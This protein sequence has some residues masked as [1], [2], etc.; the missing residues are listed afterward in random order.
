MTKKVIIFSSIDFRR[1]PQLVIKRYVEDG[2]FMEI[3]L[4]GRDWFFCAVD[5]VL[6][7]FARIHPLLMRKV[8]Y[9]DLTRM[10]GWQTSAEDWAPWPRYRTWQQSHSKS[11]RSYE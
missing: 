5:K 9:L 7:T 2:P 10:S 8:T 6:A 1:S 4:D 11:S 3:N